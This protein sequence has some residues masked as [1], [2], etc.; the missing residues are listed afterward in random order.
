MGVGTAAMELWSKGLVSED[1]LKEVVLE[2]ELN[3]V[4]EQSI[5]WLD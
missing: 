2:A 3:K 4:M 1:I 5:P